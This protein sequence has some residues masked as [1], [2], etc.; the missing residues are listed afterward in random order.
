MITR[1]PVGAPV[2]VKQAI[3]QYY[4]PFVCFYIYIYM[5]IIKI[6]IYIEHYEQVLFYCS[7]H[8]TWYVYQ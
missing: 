8:I 5:Y 7:R 6:D 1:L 3:N 2:I 4:W